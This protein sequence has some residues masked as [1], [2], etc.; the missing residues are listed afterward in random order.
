MLVVLG[1]MLFLG[2]RMLM[3]RQANRMNQQLQEQITPETAR[4]AVL[5][6]DDEQHKE[7]YRAIAAEDG[8]RALAVFKQSTGASV[9]DCIV[10]VQALHQ[11]PQ[12][13]P[14]EI[15]FEEGFNLNNDD[16]SQEEPEVQE[17]YLEDAIDGLRDDA[18]PQEP[19]AQADPNTG[20]ILGDNPQ[21]VPKIPSDTVPE[22][23]DD[24]H[25]VDVRARELMAQSGFDPE[26]ELTVPDDWA[27]GEDEQAGFHLEVQRGEEKIT[28]S[29]D[30][31]EPWVHDQ[32]YALLRDDHVDEAAQLLSEHSPLTTEEAHRFLVVFKDQ[33]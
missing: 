15:R 13:A 14:S 3:Q 1:I 31:L 33:S 6:L 19:L 29:H 9:R 12:P 20:E 11:F 25:D 17:E 16:G 30:D 26:E 27:S 4:Q 5:A 24:E 10:A 22:S 21:Q 7:V 8:R 28:L 2:I 18:D 32:L 23:N